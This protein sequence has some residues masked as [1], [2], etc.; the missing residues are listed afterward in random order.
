[1]IEHYM[2]RADARDAFICA[3]HHNLMALPEGATIGTCSPRR[4]ALA[5]AQRADL[6]IVQ[7]RGNVKTRLDKVAAGQVDATYL[8]MAGLTRLGI[9]DPMIH[10]IDVEE[11]L[12]ACG[13]GIVCVEM[14]ASDQTTREILKAIHDIPTGYCAVAEREVLKVLDGSCHTPIA[15]YATYNDGQL[16]LRSIVASLDGQITY[17][18]E[19]RQSCA[20]IDDAQSIGLKV[21]QAIK[22]QLPEGFLS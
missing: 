4:Q 17:S 6:K 20:S 19:L 7:F 11:M 16:Y 13:Q 2:A 1:M 22:A 5:L 8:A 3:N 14:R 10:A 15:A 9:N 21:G 12:P 18:E